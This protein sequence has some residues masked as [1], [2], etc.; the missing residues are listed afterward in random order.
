MSREG[1]I[2][3]LL[4]RRPHSFLYEILV[5]SQERVYAP[6]SYAKVRFGV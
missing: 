6:T 2:S 3:I 1:I 4:T 5:V